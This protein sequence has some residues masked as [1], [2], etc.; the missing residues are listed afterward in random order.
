MIHEIINQ[1]YEL[2]LLDYS[3]IVIFALTLW[4]ILAAFLNSKIIW[5]LVNALALAVAT[6]LIFLVT[7]VLRK[8]ELKGVSIIPFS[9]FE[10]ARIHPDVYNQIMMNIL[11][12]LPIGMAVPFVLCKKTKHSIF[13]T[14]F[15]AIAFS[16]ITEL[17]QYFFHRGYAEIDDVI[18]NTLGAAI[19][20][21][22]YMIIRLFNKRTDKNGS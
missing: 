2:S 18:F 4:I 1:L 14:L 7:I 20:I 13:I 8:T 12:Y 5:R 16:T 6:V 15:F 17:L 9:S 11:L 19:G 21:M 10:T 22:P 3:L